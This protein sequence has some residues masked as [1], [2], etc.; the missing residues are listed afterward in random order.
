MLNRVDIQINFL[1]VDVD[2]A[3]AAAVAAIVI[4]Y[5]RCIQ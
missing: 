4:D 3:A 2:V 5:Y 1:C